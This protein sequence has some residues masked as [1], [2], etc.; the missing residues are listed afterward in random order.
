MR[1]RSIVFACAFVLTVAACA[2]KAP[3]P[4][5][6]PAPAPA[7]EPAATAPAATEPS[8]TPAAVAPEDVDVGALL[9]E[10]D[11]PYEI[12]EDED[13][14]VLV[15]IDDERTQQVWV[16]SVIESTDHFTVREIWSR[17][18]RSEGDAFDAAI[19][20]QLLEHG[21]TIKLGGWVKNGDSAMF[22]VKIPADAN[23]DELDE[24]IDLAAVT[25]DKMELELTAKD[26]F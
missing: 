10:K 6:A 20:N 12:D 1:L 26:D 25:A 15:R 23:A 18:Y 17:A 14:A 5:P 19:A 16:R 2:E 9:D 11:T 4:A 21:N 8:A 22:V 7:A 24:A 13:Y 3:E